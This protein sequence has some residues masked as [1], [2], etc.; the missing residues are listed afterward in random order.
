MAAIATFERVGVSDRVAL[1]VEGESMINDAVG[2][3]AYKLALAAV[4]TGTFA[5][6]D[7]GLDLLVAVV[8][9]IAIGLAVAAGRQ[10]RAQAAR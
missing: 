4:V 6:A 8:G 10:L 7:A 3:V 2:L 5:V 9:G 1:L